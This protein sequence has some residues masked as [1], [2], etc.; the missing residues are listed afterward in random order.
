MRNNGGSL[1]WVQLNANADQ[2]EE[3]MPLCRI[4]F[5]DITARKPIEV[6]KTTFEAQYQ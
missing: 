6:E 4:V 1:L 2:G 5:S 3:G